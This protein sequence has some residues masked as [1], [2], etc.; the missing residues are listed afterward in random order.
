MFDVRKKLLRQSVKLNDRKNDRPVTMIE[1]YEDIAKLKDYGR[2]KYKGHMMNRE[3][4]TY[5]LANAL[6]MNHI[7][8][9]TIRRMNID[10]EEKLGVLVRDIMEQFGEPGYNIEKAHNAPYNLSEIS[11]L[12]GK[13]K[14]LG[15]KLAFELLIGNMDRHQ[16]NWMVKYNK[17]DHNDAKMYCFDQ[18]LSFPD[19]NGTYAGRDFFNQRDF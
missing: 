7:P 10:G 1:E 13:D 15:D 6:K 17:N 2:E 12:R 4:A 5:T 16:G 19:N 18:G 3:V 11:M 8:D 14:Q 9:A